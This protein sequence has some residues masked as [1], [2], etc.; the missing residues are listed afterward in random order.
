M[1]ERKFNAGKVL[2]T[3][4]L[5]ILFGV[6]AHVFVGL[7]RPVPLPPLPH[8]NG[9]DDFVKAQNLIVGNPTDVQRGSLEQL[10]AHLAE[11]DEVL[12]LVR[13]GLGKQCRVPIAFST[14]HLALRSL[15]D[16]KRV[17]RLLEAEGR[18]AE[19]EHRTNEAARIY[20]EIIRYGEES[21]R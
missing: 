13:V 1:P 4:G 10:R 3:G 19:L 15:R 20:M 16:V 17:A 14:N 21:C 2:W 5:L 11:N 6:F 7:N 12:R 9:N 8:P 18:L